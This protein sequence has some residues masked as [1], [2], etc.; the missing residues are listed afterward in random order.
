MR[1]GLTKEKKAV[2]EELMICEVFISVF[3]HTCAVC[4][5]SGG[6]PAGSSGGKLLEVL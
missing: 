5:M 6:E 2:A 1:E 3:C 4:M